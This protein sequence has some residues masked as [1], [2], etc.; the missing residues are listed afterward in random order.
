MDD[1]VEYEFNNFLKDMPS[2]K[3]LIYLIADDYNDEYPGN[4]IN[5]MQVKLDSRIRDYLKQFYSGK[6]CI[7][8]DWCVHV[9]PK[10]I[11]LEV[12]GEKKSK[13]YVV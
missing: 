4:Q 2:H 13:F 6:Y 11:S 7:Y 9:V 10:N 5:I 3:H 12:L 8:S 1:V